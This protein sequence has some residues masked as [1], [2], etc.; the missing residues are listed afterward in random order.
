MNLRN[1]AVKMYNTP[2][3]FFG[4]FYTLRKIYSASK[5]GKV[6]QDPSAKEYKNVV[7]VDHDQC[8][9]DL[10]KEAVAFGLKLPKKYVDK[11]Y[12]FSIKSRL[13]RWG[14]TQG[15]TFQLEDVVDG[16]ENGNPVAIA[17]VWDKDECEELQEIANDPKLLAIAREYLGYDDVKFDIK[18]FWTFV[19]N[20][21]DEERI[22]SNQTIEYHFDVHSWNFCYL[23]FYITDTDR[24]SGAHQLVKKSHKRK[25]LKWLWGSAKKSD[26]QIKKVYPEE[27]IVMIEGKAGDGFFE[28]TSC[29]HRAVAP[30][31]SN[32]LL[33]QVRYY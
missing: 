4:R 1:V 21:T 19:S 31:K 30:E 23:H 26:E 20:M 9:K 5:K 7:P 24:Y 3:Y 10:N 8:V 13:K 16:K 18:L 15:V 33:L 27:D 28:D 14:W 2:Q 6:A 22:K 25:P 29:Y 17:E 12:D 32:R 11:I